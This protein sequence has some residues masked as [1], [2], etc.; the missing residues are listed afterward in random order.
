MKKKREK[1]GYSVWNN[2]LYLLGGIWCSDKRLMVFMLLETVCMVITPYAAMYLPKAGVDLAAGQASVRE[3]VRVLGG[4]TAVITVSQ[5]AGSMAVRGKNVRQD[6]LRSYYR[7]RL[8]CKTLD[9]DYEHVESAKWQ[10]KYD[11]AKEMSVD[12]G[13]WSATTLMSEGAVKVCGAIV[14]F[15]LYG[16]IIGTLSPWMMVMIIAL[17]ALNFIALRGAQKYEMKR[18]AERSALQRRREYIKSCSSDIKYGKDIR[19]YEMSGW[20]RACFQNYNNAHFRLRQDV[21]RRYFGAALVEAVTMYIRDG[22]AYLYFL[23]LAVLGSI[24]TGDFVLV[25]SAVAAF[26]AL[27]TQTADSIGQMMQAVPPLNRMRNYLEAADESEP[28]PAAVPPRRG[29]A[30]SVTFEDVSFSYEGN[31]QVLNHFNLKI[32]AGEKIALVGINGAGKTTII[33]LLCGFYKPDSGRILLNGQD[34]SGFRKDDLYRLTAPVFQEATILPFTIA[35]NVSMREKEMDRERIRECLCRVGLWEKISRLPEGMDSMMMNL[36]EKGGI[37]LSGGQQQKLLMAR[38][39]YKGA[40]LLFFDEPTAALDPI[41]ESETYEM[42][43]QLSGD[44]TAV[45][46]SHRLASTRFCDRIIFL[47][48]GRVKAAGSHEELLKTCAEY[49]NM[50]SVQSRYYKK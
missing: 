11:E 26:S 19:L 21:Q 48:N 31:Y 5:A 43:H 17:S 40:M 32:D 2:F 47:E 49:A 29:E 14:S 8:F 6:R 41:A 9:C 1:G 36:E 18:I 33:K 30:V 28:E 50:Y 42:F 20:I 15:G 3:A 35:Q 16:R 4:L 10:D 45:Y 34:V 22:A 39:L 27:V 46:I 7:V 44:K 37:N 38:A 25:C 13:P 23:W 12:W 24:T